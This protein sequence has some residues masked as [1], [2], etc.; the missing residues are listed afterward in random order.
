MDFQKISQNRTYIMG[1]AMILILMFHTDFLCPHT[2]DLIKNF[3][4]FG[5]NIFFCISGF[6]MCFAW[7]KQHNVGDFLKKR[8]LRIAITFLPVV[9][10]WCMFCVMMREISLL[11]AVCK[12]LTIQFWIDG[13][14][15]H[16]FISG[17]LVFYLVTP[18]WMK[19]YDK[20]RFGCYLVTFF[21]CV[22]QFCCLLL[23]Y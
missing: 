2:L 17:I 16:W 13:N 12:I 11:E 14:L 8:F 22:V 5:V 3:G 18:F 10:V 20:N 1:F 7:E 23:V 15:L 6:S 9:I 4:D 21:L 19:L